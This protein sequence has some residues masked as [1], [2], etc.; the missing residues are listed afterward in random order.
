MKQLTLTLP[1]LELEEGEKIFDKVKQQAQGSYFV[2][3]K[4]EYHLA[5]VDE[6]GGVYHE[7]LPIGVMLNLERDQ[8]ILELAIECEKKSNSQS[9]DLIK[10]VESLK[11]LLLEVLSAA[12]NA[13]DG[14]SCVHKVM[15]KIEEQML[16]HEE[17]SQNIP[18]GYVSEAL[19]LKIIESV[20]K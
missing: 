1:V 15:S 2:K 18:V 6:H 12:T 3:S 7:P 14:V 9:L 4:T 19:L 5:E 10:R 11:S 17:P 16:A 8:T 13:S 20:R